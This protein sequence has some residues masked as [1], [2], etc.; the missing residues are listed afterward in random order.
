MVVGVVSDTRVV[1]GFS[2]SFPRFFLETE[3]HNAKVTIALEGFHTRGDSNRSE[4][5]SNW[6]FGRTCAVDCLFYRH[7]IRL[8]RGQ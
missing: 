5:E 7:G 3:K 6:K 8:G 4:N 1:N 2:F